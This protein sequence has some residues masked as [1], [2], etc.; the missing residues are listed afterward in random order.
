MSPSSPQLAQFLDQRGASSA[1][2]LAGRPFHFH[3]ESNLLK[4][5]FVVDLPAMVAAIPLD[6]VVVAPLKVFRVGR[7]VGSY[8]GAGL[9]LLA[10]TVE[11]LT[12]GKLFADWMEQ[13]QSGARVLQRL[14]RCWRPVIALIA[15]LTIIATPIVNRRSQQLGFRHASISFH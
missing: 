12:L 1:T 9:M 11:W 14:N 6:I 8:F 13:K 10:G 7:F 2:V 15:L 5:L 3:Y 4:C